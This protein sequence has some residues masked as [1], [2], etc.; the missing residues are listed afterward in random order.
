VRERT[1]RD[2]SLK[3]RTL[4]KPTL[5]ERDR[6]ACIDDKRVHRAFRPSRSRI[7]DGVCFLRRVSFRSS[8]AKAS[9]QD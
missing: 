1:T 8:A 6:D 9:K 2:F 7:S 5:S 3:E 4:R